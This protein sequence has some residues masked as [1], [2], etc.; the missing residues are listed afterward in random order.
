[1]QRAGRKTKSRCKLPLRAGQR[2]NA[3]R[4]NDE[5][6]GAGVVHSRN[7]AASGKIRDAGKKLAVVF[8]DAESQRRSGDSKQCRIYHLISGARRGARGWVRPED[9]TET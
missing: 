7:A 3:T 4:G 9:V 5:G 1:M 8:R 6:L 2:Y